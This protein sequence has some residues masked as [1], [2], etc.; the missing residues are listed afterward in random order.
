[1]TALA[2]ILTLTASLSPLLTFARLWQVKEW[3]IDRLREHLRSEGTVRQLFGLVRP[4]LLILLY[5][6]F[7]LR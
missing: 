1:M 6:V 5:P 3:R 7:F 2:L 4:V